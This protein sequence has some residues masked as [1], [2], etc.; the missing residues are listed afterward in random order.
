MKRKLGLKINWKFLPLAALYIF[1][2]AYFLIRFFLFF[3]N[4]EGVDWQIFRSATL[5]LLESGNPYLEPQFYNPPW[6]LIPLIPLVFL[7]FKIGFALL[8]VL[9]VATYSYLLIKFGANIITALVLLLSPF[10]MVALTSG[11]ID[12]IAVIGVLLPPQIGLIFVLSKPQ[13]CGLISIIW[14]IQAWKK[15]RWREIITVF[16][17]VSI[18]FLISFII[19]GFYPLNYKNLTG[20][21]VSWNSSF[22]PFSIPLGLWLLY[23]SIKKN[24][25][26]YAFPATPLLS[27]YFAYHSLP[28]AFIGLLPHQSIVIIS[29]VITWLLIPNK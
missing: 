29:I 1:V 10:V 3:P 5:H 17:P 13:T 16:L 23:K 11:Q 15:G 22:W 26:N 9:N 2:I 25:L 20:N 18:L 21:N 6:I 7:P 19:F 27:P 8:M 28:I 24:K 12:F 4:C 14:L